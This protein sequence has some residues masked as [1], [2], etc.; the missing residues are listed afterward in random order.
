MDRSTFRETICSTH[1]F[2]FYEYGQS[3]HYHN[4]RNSQYDRNY[5]NIV[6]V[7]KIKLE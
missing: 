2:R 7:T 4:S 3:I 6:P 5:R 1:Y